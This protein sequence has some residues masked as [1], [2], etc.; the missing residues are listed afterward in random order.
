MDGKPTINVKLDGETLFVLARI[1]QKWLAV[2]S[3]GQTTLTDC[4]LYVRQ[5]RQMFGNGL[6]IGFFRGF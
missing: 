2:H 1:G 4:I 3:D 5:L 6:K